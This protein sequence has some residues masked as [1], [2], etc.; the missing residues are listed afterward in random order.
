MAYPESKELLKAYRILRV[1]PGDSALTIK[2]AYRR[3]VRAFH[4][5]RFPINTAS[6]ANA[7][8]QM[9]IINEAYASCLL[10]TFSNCMIIL[11]WNL[12]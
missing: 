1:S 8:E 6:K 12:S 7:E 4:P 5:D 2:R 9:K 3:L 10:F 11:I